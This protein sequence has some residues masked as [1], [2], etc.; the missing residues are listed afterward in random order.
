MTDTISRISPM[1]DARLVRAI[2]LIWKEAD[3]LD[4]KDY[5]NWQQL[6]TDD[7]LYIVPIER[8]NDDFVNSLNM[9]YDDAT[10]R[11]LRVA[12][13]TEGYAIA[14]IDA[15]QTIRTVSRFVPVAVSDTEVV[16]RSA[17]VIVAFKRGVHDLWA[18]EVTHAIRLAPSG[19]QIAQKVIR[20]IDAEDAVPAAG[21][22]L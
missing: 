15:A 11:Q 9:I 4:R 10:M 12:R 14:A 3:L 13:M 6:Y 8:D 1:T 20:L 19:D 7:A 18:G 17:Q 2:E 16:V 21:F 5:Q 22:L